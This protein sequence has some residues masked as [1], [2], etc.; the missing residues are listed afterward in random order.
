MKTA[1]QLIRLKFPYQNEKEAVKIMHELEEKL[2]QGG[3]E[4][5]M[6]ISLSD[7]KGKVIIGTIETKP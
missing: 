3:A 4:N 6:T 2:K 7:D 1:T 5:V